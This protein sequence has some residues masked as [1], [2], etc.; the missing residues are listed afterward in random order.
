MLDNLKS[1]NLKNI[2]HEKVKRNFLSKVAETKTTA[3]NYLPSIHVKGGQ[4]AKKR[5][6]T[7]RSKPMLTPTIASKKAMMLLNMGEGFSRNRYEMT[8]DKNTMNHSSASS[9]EVSLDKVSDTFKDVPKQYL[10][11]RRTLRN[12]SK[13]TE[14]IGLNATKP[15]RSTFRVRRHCSSD[16][17]PKF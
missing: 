12:S 9:R 10:S 5:M 14:V 17:L 13:L 1:L 7:N 8:A 15:K 16:K 3:S 6:L 4:G 2:T 11:M